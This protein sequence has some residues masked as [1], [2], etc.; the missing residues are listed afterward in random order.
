MPGTCL[1]G[2][3]TGLSVASW[4]IPLTENG[5]PICLSERGLLRASPGLCASSERGLLRASPGALLTLASICLL[6][7]YL[8]AASLSGCCL[9]IWLL[10]VC[11]CCRCWPACCGCC[12]PA[13][14]GCCLPACC[15][16]G[17]LPA[18]GLLL[19]ACLCGL[20]LVAC[21]PVAA[22]LGLLVCLVAACLLV[23]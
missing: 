4:L 10:P 11:C 19:P 21:L 23:C 16:C 7:L 3:H 22:C 2:C 15:G 12:L 1:F 20:W 13:C 17:L 18:C 6:P 8:A 5:P 14:F 9:S